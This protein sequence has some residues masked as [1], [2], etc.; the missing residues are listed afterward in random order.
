VWKLK[1]V[2]L[3]NHPLEANARE[4][5]TQLLRMMEVKSVSDVKETKD[6][7]ILKMLVTNVETLAKKNLMNTQKSNP[8]VL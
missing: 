3:I 4:V 8:M 7:N 5:S 6:F 2:R 1:P